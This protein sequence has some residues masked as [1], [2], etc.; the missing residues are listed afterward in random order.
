MFT[1]LARLMYRRC[2]WVL[3]ISGI[4]LFGVIA[5]LA[6]GGTLTTGEIEGT[7]SRRTQRLVEGMAG[8][9]GDSV[10]AAIYGSPEWSTGDPR[11]IQALSAVVERLKTNPDV[12]SVT[13]PLE[14][15]PQLSMR[16][17]SSDG[18]HALVVVRLKGDLRAAA[19]AF[20]KLREQLKQGPLQI[21]VTG[22]PAFLSDL[23][24]LLERDLVRAELVSLPL[25]LLVLLLVFRTWVAAALPVGVGAMA[26]MTGVAGVLSLSRVTQM[27]Q[28]TI[29]VVT[30]IGLGVAIDYSLFIVSRFRD[31]LRGGTTVEEALVRAVD[32]SGRAVAFS[33]LAVAV[34]LSGLL[35]YRGSYLS[36]MGIAGAIVVACAVVYALTLLPAL[37]AVLGQNIE[38]GRVPLPRFADRPGLWHSISTWVM[39]HPWWV[40]APTLALLLL[41]GSPFFRLRMAATDITALP[42]TSEARRGAEELA[43]Y[44]PREA[45]NRIVVA[46]E[47]PSGD[48]FTPERVGALYDFSRQ[49]AALPGVVA[50]ESVVDLDPSL[51]RE[52]Y[53]QLAAMPRN[54]LPPDFG[55]AERTFLSGSVTVLY[56]LANVPTT[57]PKA[58][59]LVRRIRANRTVADGRVWVGGQTANNIDAMEYIRARTPLALGFVMGTSGLVLFMLLGSVL[60]PLK[61]LA[62]NLL[63]IAGS[64]GALVWIFQEGNLK[65]LLRFE[66]GPIEPSLPI[67]LFC[68]VFG[69]SMDY[70]VLLLSRIQEE[71]RLSGDN[72]HSVA[73][74]LERTGGQITSAAAIMV[75]VFAAFTLATVVVVKAMGLGMAIAVAIDATLVR[76]LIVPATMRLFGDFNWWAPGPVARFFAARRRRSQAH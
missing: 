19:R 69:L 14:G 36:A 13:S 22:K 21:S 6:R 16:F 18:H 71:F 41:I 30:L 60:L 72:T 57:S 9:S 46:V 17:F 65:D 39:R 37:L 53:L 31:E 8:L 24:A 7:E 23:D 68:A 51:T 40:L 50:V 64:F 49:L 67:L 20:P 61:A 28:Y 63:S 76:V 44:F 75:A 25:A 1:A 74:G 34:G 52:A 62:M 5:A 4:A 42:P 47:F 33:G 32:T 56:V 59:D 58:E 29:N 43:R 54:F 70:E 45:A 35:F 12:Q 15:P 73:E 55:I 66:P 10:V 26:V 2:W 48:P 11:F 38:R 27:A 3:A